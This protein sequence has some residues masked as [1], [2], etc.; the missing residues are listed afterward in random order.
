[1]QGS[2]P[3]ITVIVSDFLTSGRFVGLRFLG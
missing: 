1:L 2:G 3:I